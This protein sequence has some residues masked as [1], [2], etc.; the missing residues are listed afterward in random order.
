MYWMVLIISFVINFDFTI[1]NIF[2]CNEIT[3]FW[4]TVCKSINIM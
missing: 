3:Y 1:E 4:E 2:F